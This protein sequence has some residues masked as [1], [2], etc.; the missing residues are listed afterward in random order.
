[1]TPVQ[2][3]QAAKNTIAG[4]YAACR[5]TA[6]SKR[7]SSGND[8]KYAA[9]IVTCETK[10]TSAWQKAIAKATKANV[11]CLDAPLTELEFQEALDDATTNVASALAGSGLINCGADLASCT[12]DVASCT[13]DLDTCNASLAPCTTDLATCQAVPKGQRLQTGQTTCWNAGG[14]V[15]PCAGSGQDGELQKGLARAYTDNGDGT[16]TDARTGLMWEKLS[17]DG[18]LHDRDGTYTWADA[19]AVKIAGLN[20]GGG[21]AGHTDWRLPNMDELQSLT[22]FSASSPAVSAAFNT[23]C[24][25][26]C[27]VTTCSCTALG[28]HWSSTAFVLAPNFAWLID[29][30]LGTVFH[31][32]KSTPLYARGVRGG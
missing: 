21:F 9:A 25:A 19:F 14:S 16:I 27:T 24:T 3:C 23:A 22:N 13:D 15:I 1:V 26:S 5:Q 17:D 11:A 10:F 12:D 18:S 20:A 32:L 30:N 2:K 4:K 8:V 7:A 29:F 31:D 6:E 28:N